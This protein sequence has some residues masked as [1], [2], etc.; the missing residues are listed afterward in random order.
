MNYPRH[1]PV[2]LPQRSF[3]ESPL[4]CHGRKCFSL[5]GICS[6]LLLANHNLI[7]GS[8][9]L[10]A[11]SLSPPDFCVCVGGC[12]WVGSSTCVCKGQ[13]RTPHSVTL[14]RGQGWQSSCLW[15]L[16][17]STRATGTPHLTVY[18]CVGIQTRVFTLVQH[19]LSVTELFTHPNPH[20]FIETESP[21]S[22]YVDWELAILLPQLHNCRDHR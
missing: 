12:T 6:F 3:P 10:P 18:I 21:Y 11:L 8:S 20:Y 1:L 17:H 19:V 16:S 5:F 22:A 14:N 2:P 13:R 9:F 7:L 15:P 4:R